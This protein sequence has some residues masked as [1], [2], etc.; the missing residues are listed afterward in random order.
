[1]AVETPT[2]GEQPGTPP[3]P[4]NNPPPGNEPPPVKQEPPKVNGDPPPGEQKP[5][6]AGDWREPITDKEVKEFAAH[7]ASPADLAKAGL[8]FRKAN[9][10]MIKVPNEKSTPEDIAKFN[11]L[12][13]AGEKPED[14]KFVVKEGAEPNEA[15]KK[16]EGKVAEILHKNHVPVAVSGELH[17][18][19]LEIAGE[20]Q[21]EQDRVAKQAR[22][23]SE[24]GLRK[25]WGADYDANVQLAIRARQTFGSQALIEF[26]NNTHVNGAKLGDHPELI[27]A[28]GQIGRRMGEGQFIGA[29]PES[30]K[31]SLEQQRNDLTNQ[32][33]NALDKGD[34][35]K[36]RELDAQR[37]ALTVKLYGTGE[38][39]G[40]EGRSA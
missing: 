22:E 29:V 25:E 37:S 11:K 5:P 39:V 34:K 20:I 19:V 14:Y 31:A 13:G 16:I 6:A 32:I 4:G 12:L 40:R 1:M 28:F 8:D 18:A 10:S 15:E 26:L 17:A 27:K 3:I 9:S 23:T 7:Y 30:E 36:A 33:Q 21:N 24:A 38:I 35:Q 2:P